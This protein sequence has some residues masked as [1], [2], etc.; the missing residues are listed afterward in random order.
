MSRKTLFIIIA[1]VLIVGTAFLYFFLRKPQV[2]EEV[3]GAIDCLVFQDEDPTRPCF[4]E[5]LPTLGGQVPVVPSAVGATSVFESSCGT[6][7]SVFEKN[8]CAAKLAKE[9]Q[10]EKTCDFVVGSLAKESCIRDVAAPISAESVPTKISQSYQDFVERFFVSSPKQA[11]VSSSI[12]PAQPAPIQIVPSLEDAFRYSLSFG[13][14]LAVYSASKYQAAPGSPIKIY[15]SGFS[16][17]ENVLNIGQSQTTLASYDGTILE[18]NAPISVGEYEIWVTNQKGTSRVPSRPVKITVTNSPA[19]LPIIEKAT[20]S[21]VPVDGT[22]TL[23][24]TGFA[25]SNNVLTSLGILENVPSS[26]GKTI[27]FSISSLPYISYAKA[28]EALRGKIS[29]VLVNIQTKGGFTEKQ[30]QFD[31]Q[32]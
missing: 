26:D 15:G 25:A 9:N 5:S 16:L 22:V 11:A 27:S 21:P 29:P 18:A 28:A 1:F 3:P 8:N 30:F 23:S 19:D 20:P 13:A 7:S 2:A 17:T 12:T 24:G 14:P 31:V 6:L 32:F 10:D 4:R